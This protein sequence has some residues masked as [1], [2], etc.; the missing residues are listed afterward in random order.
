MLKAAIHLRSTELVTVGSV[1]SH[2]VPRPVSVPSHILLT[3]RLK[4][5]HVLKLFKIEPRLELHASATK[6][7]LEFVEAVC[8]NPRVPHCI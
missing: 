2:Q 4:L 3:G 1:Q 6:Q 8:G 7:S 5:S